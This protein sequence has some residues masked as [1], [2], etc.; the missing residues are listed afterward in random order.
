MAEETVKQG[1]T[2]TTSEDTKAKGTVEGLTD[3]EK[4]LAQDKKLA[5]EAASWRIKARELEVER[6]NAKKDAEEAREAAATAAGKTSGSNEREVADLKTKLAAME[7]R[8]R[9]ATE[10]ANL[11]TIDAESHRALSELGVL[12]I[13]AAK[14]WLR[15]DLRVDNDGE[16]SMNNGEEWGSF[17][18]EA[19][20]K[21]LPAVFM[22]AKAA[23][24]SGSKGSRVEAKTDG[25]LLEHGLKDQKF[26][27]ENEPEI[28][29]QLKGGAS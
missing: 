24:G 8:E 5:K 6:D 29:R 13:E 9:Q 7:Q 22:P 3:D 17:T 20:R 23:G 14:R 27:N 26:W 12:D 11:K 10:R 25:T 2:D 19:L 15:S 4:K 16:L 21:R 18:V 1:E 28:L